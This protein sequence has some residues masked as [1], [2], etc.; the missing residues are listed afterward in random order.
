MSDCYLPRLG[1]IEVQVDALAHALRG[2]GH[3]VR[4]I[5]ATPG[6]GPDETGVVRMLPPVPLPMPINPW[7]G[8]ALRAE[9]A[10]ADVVHAHLGVITPFASHAVDLALAAGHPAVVSWHSM[11]GPVAPALRLV[12][13][14]RRWVEAGVLPTAVSRAAADQVESALGKVSGPAG[15]RHPVVQVLPN[16]VYPDQWTMAGGHPPRAVGQPV[17][18]VTATRFARRKRPLRL[19]QMLLQLRAAVPAEV[20][21]RAVIAG[22][23][24]M[25]ERA[26][27]EVRKAGAQDWIELPGRLTRPALAEVYHRSQIYLSPVRLESFGLAALEARTAGLVVLGLAG[28]GLAEFVDDGRTGVLAHDDADL[29]RRTAALLSDP[30]GALATMTA[31]VA[32]A[33][34][35]EQTWPGVAALTETA[36]RLAMSGDL[37]TAL[38]PGSADG[39]AARD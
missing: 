2:R 3:D 13:Q 14:W 23:G 25:R 18:L 37:R 22:D 15:D 30:D 11:V 34:L 32:D 8:P 9:L 21:L 39:A 36:Y 6:H 4:V 35:P 24:P 27:A 33:G 31:A 1:G 17:T 28:S 7:A 12:G 20:P 19:V 38:V 26:V 29:V 5:T 10:A 16:A